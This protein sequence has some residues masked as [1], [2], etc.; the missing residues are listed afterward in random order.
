MADLAWWLR[1]IGPAIGF[2]GAL[3]LAVAQ[4]APFSET[5]VVD[6]SGEVRAFVILRYPWLWKAGLVLL[7]LGFVFQTV[8]FFYS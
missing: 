4:Q 3:S 2:W 7:V 5:G 8:G 1:W 6:A